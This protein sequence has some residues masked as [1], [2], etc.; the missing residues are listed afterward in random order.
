MAEF[1]LRRFLKP[2]AAHT[3]S[4]ETLSRLALSCS[5]LARSGQ[6]LS[7]VSTSA[8]AR[9]GLLEV[10]AILDS[11]ARKSG[12]SQIQQAAEECRSLAATVSDTELITVCRRLATNLAR[13]ASTLA[14]EVRQ[15]SQ[16][17]L[18]ESSRPG[19]LPPRVA[20]ASPNA[21]ITFPLPS[22]GA[23][24]MHAGEPLAAS[25]ARNPQEELSPARITDVGKFRTVKLAVEK[26]AVTVALN[27]GARFA[28][29][30][31]EII[32]DLQH[33]RMWL[34]RLNTS[35]TYREALAFLASCRGGG[36][37]DWRLPQ[38]EEVQ[39][40]LRAGGQDWMAAQGW[41]SK[42]AGPT[43]E[44]CVWT[45]HTRWRWLRFRREVTV[46]CLCSR[47]S[48]IIPASL[49]AVRFLAVR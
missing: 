49:D 48:R 2:M 33:D 34:A 39:D 31:L 6:I 11:D 47:Q 32:I 40:L 8:A 9:N 36:Y 43:A 17:P 25:E 24:P 35:G 19:T 28:Q 12:W 21:S 5:A 3:P 4:N 29:V 30:G 7:T 22:H 16:K 44:N 38:P 23:P 10:A 26:Q 18:K 20:V 37:C 41:F 46:V 14:T 13:Q 42:D 1:A 45:S 15:Q 27:T